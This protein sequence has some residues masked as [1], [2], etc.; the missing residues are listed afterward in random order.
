[1]KNI[2]SDQS[3]FYLGKRVVSAV[4]PEVAQ[5]MSTGNYTNPG[6]WKEQW[7]PSNSRPNWL[8]SNYL[9]IFVS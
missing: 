9:R 1:M 3:T 2:I 5:Q 6:R 8:V 4:L 7:Q